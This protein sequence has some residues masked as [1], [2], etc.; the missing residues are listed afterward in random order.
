VTAIETDP[1]AEVCERTP[2]RTTCVA[3]AEAQ[4]CLA[5][6]ERTALVV[7]AV[8]GELGRVRARGGAQALEAARIN[9]EHRYDR[10]IK[11]G[12]EPSDAARSAL[13]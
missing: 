6:H 10:A 12:A 5:A 1:S 4:R 7:R 9:A 2:T 11:D 13:E 8:V 3:I